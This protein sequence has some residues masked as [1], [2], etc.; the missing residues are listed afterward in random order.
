[1]PVAATPFSCWVAFVAFAQAFQKHFNSRKSCTARSTL[2]WRRDSQR[3]AVF[4]ASRDARIGGPCNHSPQRMRRGWVS[5][6]RRGTQL[7]Y[8]K[9]EGPGS[10]LK[11][12]A[13]FGLE[14]SSCVCAP[15]RRWG[16]HLKAGQ[17]TGQ[18]TRLGAKKA[19]HLVRFSPE[20]RSHGRAGLLREQVCSLG[21]QWPQR[22]A[23][24]SRCESQHFGLRVPRC[25]FRS[26][27]S[28]LSHSMSSA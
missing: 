14:R 11:V 16:C 5:S 25:A 9:E 6:M 10:S 24:T 15:F 13:G 17:S 27:L 26:S 2:Q 23:R 28:C 21:H 8:W 18:Q 1:M 20:R 7:V 22:L 12:L 19:P 3:L 4:G